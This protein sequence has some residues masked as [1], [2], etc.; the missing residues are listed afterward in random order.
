M[1]IVEVVLVESDKQVVAFAYAYSMGPDF[2]NVF[3]YQSS[4]SLGV[5]PS[6]FSM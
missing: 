5:L 1:H 6:S 2:A 4:I 3:L